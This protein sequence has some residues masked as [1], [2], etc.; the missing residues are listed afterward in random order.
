MGDLD[1]IA[2]RLGRVA[3]RQLPRVITQACRE[4]T[5]PDHGCFDRNWWHYRMRDFPSA[6]LQQGAYML[7]QAR[8]G[9][10]SAQAGLPDTRALER[11]AAVFWAGR[12]RR[13]GAFEEYYPWER[14]YPPLAFST[15]AVAKILAEE[16][17]LV[18]RLRPSLAAA[19][20]QLTTRFEPEAANQQMAGLAALAWLRHLDPSLVAHASWARL[21]DRTLALQHPEG[22]FPEYGGADLGYLSVTVDC[23][24]DASDAS[25]GDPDLERAIGRA[26]SWAHPFVAAARG[27]IGMHN[28]RNTDYLLPFGFARAA[29]ADLPERA[30]AAEIASAIC[31]DLESPSHPLSAV[32]DRYWSHYVGHSVVRAWRVA[33]A[34]PLVEAPLS[35]PAS[36]TFPS[37][38][39]RIQ[40]L[41]GGSRLL[42]STRK[43]GNLTLFAGRMQA[44]VSDFGW[45]VRSGRLL[46]GTNW[47]GEH[48][49]VEHGADRIVVR[50]SLVRRRR[51]CATPWR[52]ALLRLASLVAGPRLTAR[53]KRLLIFERR[54]VP[55]RTERLIRWDDGDLVVDDTITGL[56]PGCLVRRGPR[57]SDRHVSSAGSYHREDFDGADETAHRPADGR[58]HA[59][60]R[61]PLPR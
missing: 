57:S 24:W 17:D 60:R 34:A 58:F 9:G 38:G 2:S 8:L 1:S 37:T 13:F 44:A 47:Q 31:A 54:L 52:H 19:A 29:A 22:W 10:L 25:G 11:A 36:R 4:P 23:L 21:R 59:S 51:V 15:L 39:H 30:L 18:P 3:V 6:I 35:S 49:E 53:L 41:P 45:V 16:P 20:A 46:A 26:V 12:A 43:G 14:G 32:D 27:S 33:R 5:S 56:D 48:W 28:S 61:I 42:V 55:W 40:V 7:Q 50:G